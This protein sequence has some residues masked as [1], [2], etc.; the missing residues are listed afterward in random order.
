MELV[1]G[2]YFDVLGVKP[3]LGRTFARDEYEGKANQFTAVISHR[4]WQAYFEGD[5]AVLGRTVRVNRHK[6]TIIGVASP[7]FRGSIPGISFEGWVALPLTGD[8]DRGARGFRAVVRLKHGVSISEAN[9]EAAPVAARLAQAHPK[10]NEGI[11][12]RIVPIWKAQSG[13]SG[14]LAS[15]LA[16]LAAACGLVLLVACAN[17]ANLLLARSAARQSEFAIRTALGAGPTRLSRQLLC[18]SLLIAAVATLVALPLAL[19]CQNTLRLFVPPTGLPLYFGVDFNARVFLFVALICLHSALLSGIPPA[20]QSVRRSMVHAIKSGGRG[21][22]QSAR[23]QRV[24][25]FFVV[26]EVGLALA[27]LVTFG[28]FV[29]S[30]HGLQDTPSGFDAR[31]V[32]LCR[33]FLVTN[34]YTAAQEQE[35]SRQLRQRLLAAPG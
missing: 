6:L 27:A 9:A 24:S 1:S 30:L 11:G 2:N 19:W 18:E 3:V 34:N 14:I 22:T 25:G 4:L 26:C 35:F 21:D 29:R 12:A 15:P 13:V 23:S 10:K 28:L 8:R 32:T 7:E 16:I 31:N 17:V 5:P 20:F 33:L